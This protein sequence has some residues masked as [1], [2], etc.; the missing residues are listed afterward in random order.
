MGKKEEKGERSR[1]ERRNRKTGK[2]EEEDEIGEETVD[3]VSKKYVCF[4]L[5][6]S[7]RN[8][9]NMSQG[10]N[11]VSVDIE[12]SLFQEENNL[13]YSISRCAGGII[14]RGKRQSMLS[15]AELSMK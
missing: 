15:Y 14:E 1:K 3:A 12:V 5:K 6:Y 9:E 8:E 2:E 7:R 13:E 4:P 11:V 10:K